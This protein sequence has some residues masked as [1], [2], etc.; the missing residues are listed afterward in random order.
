MG[1]ERA[2]SEPS[3]AAE[4]ARQA[5]LGVEARRWE[6]KPYRRFSYD[7]V[8][9]ND[10]R[11]SGEPIGQLFLRL[12]LTEAAGQCVQCGAGDCTHG[13]AE[14]VLHEMQTDPA[15]SYDAHVDQGTSFQGF[16]IDLLMR[17][18]LEQEA[19]VERGGGPA[20]TVIEVMRLVE[21]PPQ[22]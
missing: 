2:D 13:A 4:R 11:P 21:Q 6:K 14:G 7:T 1:Y 12:L 17:I 19:E 10:V 9:G 16:P 18:L 5:Y 15:F 22:E 20:T 3:Q 8:I